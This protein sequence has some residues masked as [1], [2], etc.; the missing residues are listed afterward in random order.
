MSTQVIIIL[1]ALFYFGFIIYTRRKGD[2]E[3][4]SVAGRS[5]G[6]FLIFAT[7]AASYIG[8]AMTLGLSREGF[9]NGNFIN[10]FTSLTVIAMSFVAIV[11]APIVRKRFKESFS[12]GDVMGGS[13]SHN[14]KNVKIATGIISVWLMSSI[15]IAMT[16]AGGELI[17]NAFGFPKFWSIAIITG[18]VVLYASFGGIRAT[19]Q[20]DAFQLIIFLILVP[21]LALYI[22]QDDGF[23]WASFTESNAVKVVKARENK[24]ISG[25]LGLVMFWVFGA[26][27][28]AALINRIL[29]SKNIKV[30]RTSIIL[31]GIFMSL[32]ALLTVFIGNAGAFLHPELAVSDQ[33]LLNIAEAHLPQTL[34]GL[35][36]VALI[37]VVMSSADSTLNTASIVFSEDVVGGIWKETSQTRKLN[38]AKGFTVFLG[39]MAVFIATYLTS[40]LDAVM[41]IFTIYMP[42]MIPIIILSILKKK[43]YW[44]SAIVS[45]AMGLISFLVWE[46]LKIESL[47]STFVGVL[48]GFISYWISDKIVATRPQ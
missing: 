40:V 26:G 5:L 18:I 24:T 35:F 13:Q 37:G 29:A 42:M 16:Y 32:W 15:T 1:F 47:P 44:Q 7:V 21:L 43:H 14:H 38:L 22:I 25:M 27:F 10:I 12:I 19:I 3:E 11:L 31:A 30:A 48:S 6:T 9:L 33:V 28:D 4:F 39:I 36:M 20:T 45:M 41:T 17:N 34:Y 46:Y 23:N 2:F 8:P